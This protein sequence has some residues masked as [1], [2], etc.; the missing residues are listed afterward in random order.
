MS[1]E[2]TEAQKVELVLKLLNNGL[3][4]M[5][6]QLDAYLWNPE[7]I[8]EREYPTHSSHTMVG[9]GEPGTMGWE[10]MVCKKCW[11]REGTQSVSVPCAKGSCP[12]C[13]GTGVVQ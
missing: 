3:D 2:R 1:A 10:G 8:A 4:V 7:L 11:A 5:F 12:T 13:D 9:V 6:D